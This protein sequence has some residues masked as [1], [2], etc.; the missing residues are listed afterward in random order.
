MDCMSDLLV[1]ALDLMGWRDLAMQ[2]AVENQNQKRKKNTAAEATFTIALDG[3]SG[4]NDPKLLSNRAFLTVFQHLGPEML[5]P[6]ELTSVERVSLQ[7]CQSVRDGCTLLCTRLNLSELEQLTVGTSARCASSS[8]R[9]LQRMRMLYSQRNLESAI[10][11]GS[12]G[13][14]RRMALVNDGKVS[15][16]TE[17]KPSS[18]K[19]WSCISESTP[20]ATSA[21]DAQSSSLKMKSLCVTPWALLGVDDNGRVMMAEKKDTGSLHFLP[22]AGLT[23]VE[24]SG[25]YARFGQIYVVTRTG[26][27]YG[28]GM[29]TD[30]F[31]DLSLDQACS[32]GLPIGGSQNVGK[33]V[34]IT[35]APGL[36]KFGFG[37]APVCT[38]ACGATHAVFVC[39]TGEAFAVGQG[40]EGQLGH[41]TLGDADVP[42]Q[43]LLPAHAKVRAAACGM[44]HTLLALT[45]G[46]AWGCGGVHADELPILKKSSGALTPAQALEGFTKYAFEAVPRQL[47]LLPSSDDFFVVGIACGSNSSFFLSDSGEVLFSGVVSGDPAPFGRPKGADPKIP[48][49]LANLPRIREVSVSLSVPLKVHLPWLPGLTILAMPLATEAQP[50]EAAIFRAADEPKAYLWGSLGGLFP[51]ELCL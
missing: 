10:C 28:W 30:N 9:W 39:Q 32:R 51:Q 1:G 11:I 26:E 45:N 34:L 5:S 44:R 42:V 12:L 25:V 48:H 49:K 47:D 18:T 16:S 46:E 13:C 29:A 27:V 41:D 8:S 4:E 33:P 7:A 40:K 21:G 19:A 43:M 36:G 15:T 31:G 38:V 24:A 35:S 20:T 3:A 17:P 23:G 22:V 14:N 2:I 50:I 37:S 6:C